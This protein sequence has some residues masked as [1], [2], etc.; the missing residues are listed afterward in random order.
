MRILAMDTSFDPCGI[1]LADDA[2]IVAAL[3]FRNE[4]DFARVWA[5]R[6]TT[7]LEYAAWSVSDL[8]GFAVCSGPGSFTGLR[9][10]ASAVMTMAHALNRPLLG[11]TSLELLALPYASSWRGAR[12]SVLY[13]RKGEVY[14]AAYA[15]DGR[16]LLDPAVRSLD[17]AALD[18]AGLPTPLLIIGDAGSKQTLEIPPEARRADPWLSTPHVE[19]LAREGHRRL[20]AGEGGPA[21]QLTVV[22]LKRSQVE[23]EMERK[24]L[25]VEMEPKQ[26][27]KDGS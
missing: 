4:R 16:P 9:I 10:S 17:D 5:T 3:T 24:R 15:S 12:A 2:G 22:Y 23:E 13:C 7:L 25:Q 1:A 18:L 21:D 8:E 26:L 19:L 27:E 11:I 14:R 6:L 20:E